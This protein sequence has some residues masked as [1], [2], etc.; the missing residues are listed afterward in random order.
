MCVSC[1]AF[2]K[3]RSWKTYITQSRQFEFTVCIECDTIKMDSSNHIHHSFFI[4]TFIMIGQI[5]V[6]RKWSG[7]EMGAESGN[8]LKSGF[9]LGMPVARGPCNGAACGH[10][11]QAPTLHSFWDRRQYTTNTSIIRFHFISQFACM[12]DFTS[13]KKY[14][15]GCV[16]SICS[17]CVVKLM[18]MFS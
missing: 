6:Y 18:K 12:S 16:V 9:E 13:I 17:A 14:L 10:A 5:R 2:Q 7:R 1:L 3:P 4:F 8:V 15:F 11:A